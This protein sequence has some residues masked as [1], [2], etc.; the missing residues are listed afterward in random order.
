MTKNFEPLGAKLSKHKGRKGGNAHGILAKAKTP[1]RPSKQNFRK[2]AKGMKHGPIQ[3]AKHEYYD[4]NREI[5]KSCRKPYNSHLSSVKK[6]KKIQKLV[7]SNPIAT[8]RLK[9]RSEF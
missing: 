7:S 4:T 2:E 8:F 3:H 6:A 9:C 5:I 1:T